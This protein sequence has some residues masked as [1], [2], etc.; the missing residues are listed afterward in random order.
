MRPSTS[1]SAFFLHPTSERSADLAHGYYG[2]IL[3]IVMVSVVCVEDWTV[4]V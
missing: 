4:I 1:G 3:P 2:S